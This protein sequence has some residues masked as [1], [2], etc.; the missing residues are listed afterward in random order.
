MKK[1]KLKVN[2]IFDR[3]DWDD[4]NV[5]VKYPL[6]QEESQVEKLRRELF[7]DKHDDQG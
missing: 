3:W 7:E 2:P 4:K 1:K 6:H 5:E